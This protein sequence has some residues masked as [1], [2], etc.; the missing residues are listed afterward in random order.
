MNTAITPAAPPLITA[1][2]QSLRVSDGTPWITL[3]VTAE[4]AVEYAWRRN[5]IRLFE[6]FRVMNTWRPTMI[7]QPPLYSD[8][9]DVYDCVVSNGCTAV[10]SNPVAVVVCGSTDFN[11][12]GDSGTDADIEAFFACLAGNCCPTCYPGGP[13]FNADGDSGTDADIESFFQVLAGQPC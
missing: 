2:P 8:G 7:I 6:S 1:Q 4:N 9:A 12:D 10:V 5:G 3:S 11:R 13:D